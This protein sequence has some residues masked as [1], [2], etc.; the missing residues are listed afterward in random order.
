VVSLGS[1]GLVNKEIAARLSVSDRTIQSHW[2][3]IFVKLAVGSRI[4][5]ILYCVKNEL[6]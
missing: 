3:N 4:E 5:A 6:V 2:R 1:Q